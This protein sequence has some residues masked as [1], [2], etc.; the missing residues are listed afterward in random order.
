MW[1]LDV[2]SPLGIPQSRFKHHI[3][4]PELPTFYSLF[5]LLDSDN[6]TAACDQLDISILQDIYEV[7]ISVND[8]DAL[9]CSKEICRDSSNELWEVGLITEQ[10]S[11]SQTV[12][13]VCESCRL[14]CLIWTRSGQNLT[15]KSSCTLHALK[16]TLERTDMTGYWLPLPGALLWCLLV[17]VDGAFGDN[18]L[19]TW[20]ASQLQRVWIA[21]SI[22]RWEG[23]QRSLSC[24]GWLLSLGRGSREV[25]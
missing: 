24:F 20:F 14:A 18:M 11:F 16:D 12:D 10:V 3:S 4:R 17:G 6:G 23:L 9:S 1:F 25:H 5:T 8:I 22:Y 19:Y 7:L 21:L 2:F 13:Y 15:S